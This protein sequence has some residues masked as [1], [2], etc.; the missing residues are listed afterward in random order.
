M[1]TVLSPARFIMAWIALTT[2]LGTALGCNADSENRPSEKKAKPGKDGFSCKKMLAKNK[3]CA[4]ALNQ[5][6]REQSRPQLEA[7]IRKLPTVAQNA[8]HAKLDSRLK[9]IGRRFV[10]TLTEERF[11]HRCAKGMSS[12]KKADVRDRNEMKRCFALTEC[13]AYARCLLKKR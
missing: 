6:A 4:A 3:K 13:T 1:Q 12:T 9:K 10:E 2:A 11:L 5:S 8:A 7:E